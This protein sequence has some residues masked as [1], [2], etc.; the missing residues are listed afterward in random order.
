MTL[1]SDGDVV[2]A[3][4]IDSYKKFANEFAYSMITILSSAKLAET[5][6]RD[7]GAHGNVNETI[8]YSVFERWRTVPDI[9]A[10]LSEW[11][12]RKRGRSGELS[13]SVRA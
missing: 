2:T 12:N 10:N 8:D 6:T 4:I 5:Q 9:G 7:D 3:P 11:A 1:T 13:N